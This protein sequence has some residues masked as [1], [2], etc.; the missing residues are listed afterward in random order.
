MT[1]VR[2]T[3]MELSLD[4]GTTLALLVAT[5]DDS[6]GVIVCLPDLLGSKEDLSPLLPW[7]ARAGY[8][9]VAL[10]LRGQYQSTSPE[11]STL[12]LLVADIEAV[13]DSF[14]EDPDDD[15][16]LVGVGFGGRVATETACQDP[17]AWTSL[18]LVHADAA[19][20]SD[21]ETLTLLAAGL[22]AGDT[23]ED[24]Y[25]QYRQQVPSGES[26]TRE[27]FERRR[28]LAFSRTA[29]E[30]MVQACRTMPD[31]VSQLNDTD[32]DILVV[33]SS[34]RT[35]ETP[36]DPAALA[37]ALGANLLTIDATGGTIVADHSET[38]ARAIA[39]LCTALH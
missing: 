35:A 26:E 15:A 12:P 25:Q 37:E 33:A 7:L 10:D 1:D 4:D 14:R 32:L 29:L 3:A 31:G 36:S 18:T 17:D 34:Y 39:R 11:P 22:D 30:E 24:L 19:G 27:A 5:T 2:P 20:G 16:H 13:A 8:T 9:A 28:F 6:R 21:H 38:V 23:L